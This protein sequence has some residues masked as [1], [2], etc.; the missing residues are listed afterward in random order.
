MKINIAFQKIAGRIN[1]KIEEV[2]AQICDVEINVDEVQEKHQN[3]IICAKQ[4]MEEK[5]KRKIG[6]IQGNFRLLS[7]KVYELQKKME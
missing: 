6:E 4:E 3:E 7:Q 2:Q 1:E 5:I